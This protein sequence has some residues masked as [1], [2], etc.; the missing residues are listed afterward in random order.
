[1]PNVFCIYGSQ[2]YARLSEW[3]PDKSVG[4][5]KLL[6]NTFSRQIFRNDSEP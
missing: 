3:I 2:T 5:R 1:M 6:R 4:L